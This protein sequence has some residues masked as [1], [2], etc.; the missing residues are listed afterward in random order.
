VIQYNRGDGMTKQEKMVE[1]IHNVEE[2]LIKILQEYSSSHGL[3]EKALEH[4][5][6]LEGTV[7]NETF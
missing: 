6:T 1:E 3:V 7:L 5:T 2:I 4:L